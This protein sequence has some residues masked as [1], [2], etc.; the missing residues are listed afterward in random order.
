M[1]RSMRAAGVLVLAALVAT[2]TIAAQG[3]RPQFGVA[4]GVAVPT[5]DFH[6][7]ASGEG[8][9]TAWQVLALVAFKVP[10]W[11]IGLRADGTYSA[12][13]AND[14]LKADLSASLGQPTDEKAQLL[15]VNVDLTYPFGSA[16][17]VQPYLLGGIGA[18]RVTITVTSGGSTADNSETKF[19]WN[20]GGGILY[21]MR[22]ATLFLEGRYVDVAAVSRFPKTTFLP[23]TAGLRLG[24]L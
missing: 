19:A 11:P 13:T 4:A 8:F 22:G 24:G 1:S 16:S 17:R 6:A 21:R 7:A 23:I 20:V 14:Q 18:Y 12:N 10:G 9:N 15:G 2:A 5:G 3:I